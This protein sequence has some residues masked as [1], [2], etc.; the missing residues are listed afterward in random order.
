MTMGSINQREASDYHA[1]IF[2][3]NWWVRAY[4]EV[5]CNAAVADDVSRPGVLI[6]CFT[7]AELVVLAG[8]IGSIQEDILSPAWPGQITV[9]LEGIESFIANG[10]PS[11][12]LAKKILVNLPMLRT[13]RFIDERGLC[14]SVWQPFEDELWNGSD[15]TLN[16]RPAGAEFFLG[17][18]CAFGD[19]ARKFSGETE[20]ASI[21]G[22][23]S[24]LF[25]WRSLWF[26][27][28][29]VERHLY[30]R[31]E[32]AMEWDGRWMRLDGTFAQSLS[33][34]FAGIKFEIGS[35]EKKTT[36]FI[37]KLHLLNQLGERMEAHGQITPP[38]ADAPLVGNDADTSLQL[39]WQMD[40]SRLSQTVGASYQKQVIA[41]LWNG[42][43][44]RLESIEQ[45]L[46]HV[47][48]DKAHADTRRF[49]AEAIN[50]LKNAAPQKACQGGVLFPGQLVLAPLVFLEWVCRRQEDHPLTL[51]SKL[52]SSRW[53]APIADFLKGKNVELCVDAFL[54][55]SQ[56]DDFYSAL[57]TEK[58]WTIAAN[59]HTRIVAD[60]LAQQINADRLEIP[61]SSSSAFA[62]AAPDATANSRSA[63][64]TMKLAAEAVAPP[65][66]AMDQLRRVALEELKMLR[67]S[68]PDEYTLLKRV[69]LESLDG[70]AKKVL[71]EVAQR[72]QP[73]LFDEQITQRLVKFMI[74]HP[75]A[76]K[77][78]RVN[79]PGPR[80]IGRDDASSG[81]QVVANPAVRMSRRETNTYYQ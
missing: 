60:F 20:L 19:L 51:P 66:V 40:A 62:M 16:L 8:L 48:D 26:D 31:L 45:L 59:R 46:L 42:W 61:L 9:R 55:L 52:R 79:P 37:Q 67:Q 70:N 75:T 7:P 54:T 81:A 36:S 15:L 10:D 25:V 13:P 5:V 73:R 12:T 35:N 22:A 50:C 23:E 38:S 49:L 76:W 64:E 43:R 80:T 72:M 63:T 53:F 30:L 28:P 44:K 27:L 74:E 29:E 32:K 17:Y 41:F 21:V 77:S 65:S 39:V 68:S 58:L 71:T 69:Y 24:P 3:P 57:R 14:H 56:D 2:L 78:A 4:E 47:G 34:L 11:K 33:G 18:S 6:P 1:G